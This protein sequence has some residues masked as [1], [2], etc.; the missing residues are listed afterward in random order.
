MTKRVRGEG[1]FSEARGLGGSCSEA[2]PALRGNLFVTRTVR[3][4]G[5]TE[6]SVVAKNF[7]SV[8]SRT[9]TMS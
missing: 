1:G 8:A 6:F 2:C 5:P 7:L 9:S 4:I 3:R